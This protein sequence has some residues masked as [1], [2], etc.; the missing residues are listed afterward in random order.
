MRRVSL[1]RAGLHGDVEARTR[2]VLRLDRLVS[3]THGG[4]ELDPC[5]DGGT[6]GGGLTSGILVPLAHVGVH[7]RKC[8]PDLELLIREVSS[9]EVK[10]LLDLIDPRDDARTDAT[11]ELGRCRYLRVL[12]RR[13]ARTGSGELQLRLLERLD[14]GGTASVEVGVGRLQRLNVRLQVS[15]GGRRA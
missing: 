12:H 7:V 6:G 15:D 9:E 8:E 4:D 13:W 1:H 11:V 5:V 2:A 14:D 3:G 10:L